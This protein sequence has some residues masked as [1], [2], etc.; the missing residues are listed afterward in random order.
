M[1]YAIA[2]QLLQLGATV[3]LITGPNT[4]PQPD[5]RIRLIKIESAHEMFMS[6]CEVTGID[7]DQSS[8]KSSS[9]KSSPCDIIVMAAAVADYTPITVAANKIKKPIAEPQA[10]INNSTNNNTENTN[11]NPNGLT[12]HL[13]KTVDILAHLGKHRSPTQTLMGFA[14]ETD[15]EVNNAISKLKRKN[16]T[17]IVLNSMRDSGAGFDVDTNKVRVVGW[18]GWGGEIDGDQNDVQNGLPF[19]T[20]LLKQHNDC[21]LIMNDGKWSQY[22]QDDVSILEFSLK[23][24][25]DVAIDLCRIITNHQLVYGDGRSGDSKAPKQFI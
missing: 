1:G 8:S 17:F 21:S 24:K 7:V 10:T 4:L 11:P 16:A 12:I 25:D 20:A 5:S 18:R 3:T 15:N 2:H 23:Q 14:L 13:K 9:L 6:V 19:T 22:P